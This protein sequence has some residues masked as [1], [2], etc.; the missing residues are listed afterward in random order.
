MPLSLVA[1]SLLFGTMLVRT[2]LLGKVIFL[3]KLD[4]FSHLV[5]FGLQYVADVIE[6][7]HRIG[8]QL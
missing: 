7:T 2:D 5:Y 1:A 4:L 6:A 8:H 3:P